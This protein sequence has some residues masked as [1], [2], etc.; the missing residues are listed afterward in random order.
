MPHKII[1]AALALWLLAASA[2]YAA[3]TAGGDP[4]GDALIPPDVVMAHQQALGLSDA[5]K[6]AIQASAQS[7]QQ[8]FTHVQFQLAAAT[9][10]LV[11][12]L[13]QNQVDQSKALAQLDAVLN[14]ER[15]MKHAQLT[16]MI[17][18]KNELTPEQQAMARQFAAA[19]GK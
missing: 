15:E 10:K 6:N 19:G 16:L 12:M 17:Q 18:V 2:V 13:K 7:A 3:D 11:Q 5:Q 1:V 14:L 4:M 9:E 8:R